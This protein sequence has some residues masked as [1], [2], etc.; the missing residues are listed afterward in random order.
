MAAMLRE[1]FAAVG[2][3]EAWVDESSTAEGRPNVYAIWKVSDDLATKWLGID[4]H[5]DTVTVENMPSSDAARFSGYLT[6]DV[7][8]D[9]ADQ[10]RASLRIHGRGTW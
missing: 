4:D 8:A 1:A 3:T 6:A 7:S 10:L 2:A 5:I 9:S